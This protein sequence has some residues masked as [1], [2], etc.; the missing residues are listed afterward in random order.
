MKLTFDGLRLC[1]VRSLFINNWCCAD[2]GLIGGTEPK[3]KGGDVT[4]QRSNGDSQLEDTKN[5]QSK[6]S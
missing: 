6:V 3:D 2:Q 5:G 1:S 4:K